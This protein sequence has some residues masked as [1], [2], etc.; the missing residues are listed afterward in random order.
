MVW[1]A[2]QQAG[3]LAFDWSS[4][5]HDL[6]GSHIT[7]FIIK[8]ACFLWQ[9]IIGI[10]LCRFDKDEAF[11]EIRRVLKPRGV[12]AVWTTNRAA[13]AEP[14]HAAEIFERTV[15][16]PLAPCWDKRAL[17]AEQGHD[18]QY[19]PAISNACNPIKRVVPCASVY[20]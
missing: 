10:G 14:A 5:I 19:F 17:I 9:R 8:P 7:V 1:L 4:S 12:L 13:V 18:G 3:N 15:L 2:L 11:A 6:G 20:E 16:R